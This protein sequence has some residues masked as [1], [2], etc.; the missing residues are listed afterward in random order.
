MYMYIT[1]MLIYDIMYANVFYYINNMLPIYMS[2]FILIYVIYI[3]K[4]YILYA[5][6]LMMSMKYCVC[7]I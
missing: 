5:V 1:Y 2:L 6:K 7:I 4:L 3:Y